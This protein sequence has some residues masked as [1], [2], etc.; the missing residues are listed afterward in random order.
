M[1]SIGTHSLSY[2]L[3]GPTPTPCNPSSPLVVIIPGAGDVA[4]S[5]VALERLLRPF[6]RTLLYD[7]SGLGRSERA[8]AAPAATPDPHHKSD[9]ERQGQAVTAAKDLKT[10]LQ[11]LQT[12]KSASL[13]LL[14]HSYG[15]LIAREFLHHYPERVVGM[16]LVDASTERG[17]EF[18]KVPDENIVAVMGDLSY[19]RATGLRA[20]TV[21][22]DEEWR[23]RAK[24][25]IASREG[26][27]IETGSFYEVCETLKL[28]KQLERQVLGDKPLTVIRANTASDYRA[29]YEMGVE[30]G[31]GS[32]EQR[33]KFRDLLE[34]WDKI[35]KELQEEQLGLSMNTR[36]VRLQGCGHNVHLVRPDVIARGVRWVWERVGAAASPDN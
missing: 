13:I 27:A 6:T 9:S 12:T 16:V 2:T 32:T 11:T 36:F 28:K 24:E 5:Y 15:A 18:F 1:I 8:P 30:A 20:N 31:N 26:A 17:S 14:A 10:L 21:L 23:T 34:R 29:I 19:A 3:T 35:D 33:G 25:I 7:R 4:S 22:T